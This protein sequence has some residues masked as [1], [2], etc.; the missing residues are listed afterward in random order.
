M[1]K[2]CLLVIDVQN[3]FCTGSLAIDGALEIIEPINFLM[4]K[5]NLVIACQD[6]HPENHQS[7]ASCHQKKIGEV[8][9]LMGVKQ[10]LWRDHCIQNTK[11]A[12]F[13][14]NLQT[15]YFQKIFLKGSNPKIDSYSAFYDMAKNSTGLT[16]WLQKKAIQKIYMVGLATDY[17]VK[18]SVLDAL[19]DGFEVIVVR[20]FCKAVNLQV[21]DEQKALWKM[22]EKGARV[23][24]KNQLAI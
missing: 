14:Q 13:P 15:Q 20:S 4:R 8:I 10:V 21:E 19:A 11:G 6:W 12:N 2:S 3:D 18:F 22:Q 1:G 16:N 23:I 9:N 24:T 7:F 17:C 5:F